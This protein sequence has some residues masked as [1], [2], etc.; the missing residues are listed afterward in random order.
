MYSPCIYIGVK[1]NDEMNITITI[2]KWGNSQGV[3]FT[4]DVLAELNMSVGDKLNI[5]KKGSSLILRPQAK[6]VETMSLGEILDT[7]PD[8]YS[9]EEVNWGT[10][11]G[12][13]IW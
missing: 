12:K 8:D 10:P 3:R 5:L 11:V 1:Y 7:I 2:Q 9:P 4:K 6:N 13:E